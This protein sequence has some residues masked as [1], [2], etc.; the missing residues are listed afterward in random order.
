MKRSCDEQSISRTGNGKKMAHSDSMRLKKLHGLLARLKRGKTVQNRQLHTWLGAEGYKVFE[1][2]WSNMIEVR[3]ELNSKPKSL[4]EYE[5]LLK[6]AIMLHNRAEVASQR[7]DRSASRLHEKAEEAFE[8][9]VLRLEEMIQQAPSLQMWLD[10][11]CD[12]TA[13]GDLSRDPIGMPRVITSRSP[14]NRS[15]GVSA[16]VKSIRECKI[17]AVEIEIE[18][19]TDP[20]AQSDKGVLPEKFRLVNMGAGKQLSYH[21]DAPAAFR[22]TLA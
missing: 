4:V 20:H 6:K 13:T 10:R 18:R 19:I 14:D 5:G 17:E 9:A 3:K 16:R 12:F 2:L 7:G 22:R 21:W 8:R 11:H 15:G 1:D